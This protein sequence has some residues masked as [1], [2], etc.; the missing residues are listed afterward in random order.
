MIEVKVGAHQGPHS[1]DSTQLLRYLLNTFVLII[2]NYFLEVL[3]QCRISFLLVSEE[4]QWNSRKDLI[5][6][7]HISLSSLWY[8]VFKYFPE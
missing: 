8:E 2:L 7:S 6:D 1:S 4:S 3:F 5:D